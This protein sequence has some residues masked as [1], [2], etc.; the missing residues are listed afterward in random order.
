VKLTSGGKK[1]EAQVEVLV[2]YEQLEGF[3]NKIKFFRR[4]LFNAFISPTEVAK[5]S[6]RDFGTPRL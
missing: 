1:K 4:A 5:Q 2:P 6:L 3:E